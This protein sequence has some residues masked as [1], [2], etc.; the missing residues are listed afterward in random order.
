M[1]STI[2]TFSTPSRVN[3]IRGCTPLSACVSRHFLVHHSFQTYELIMSDSC[4][5]VIPHLIPGEMNE[6][7]MSF[8]RRAFDKVDMEKGGIVN[9]MNLKKF[10]NPS[11]SD[12]MELFQVST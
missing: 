10:A 2:C 7:R 6:A 8:V 4:A 1:P 11:L 12:Q 3:E 9:F 5:L